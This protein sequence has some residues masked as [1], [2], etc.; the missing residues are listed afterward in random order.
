MQTSISVVVSLAS[1]L[2]CL[3]CSSIAERSFSLAPADALSRPEQPASGSV[4][5]GGRFTQLPKR[6]SRTLQEQLNDLAAQGYRLV[7]SHGGRLFERR[8][9]ESAR[10]EYLVLPLQRIKEFEPAINRAIAQGYRLLPGELRWYD[11]DRLEAVMERRTPSVERPGPRVSTYEFRIVGSNF[12]RWANYINDGYRVI[13]IYES[14]SD[15]ATPS[16][17]MQK[18]SGVEIA[19]PASAFARDRFKWGNAA[20]FLFSSSKL[21][22]RLN[23]YGRQ[24]YQL[25]VVGEGHSPDLL[26]KTAAAKRPEYVVVQHR[27]STTERA[28]NDA[29]SR[30]F[31]LRHYYGENT[32]VMEKLAGASSTEYRVVDLVALNTTDAGWIEEFSAVAVV[33]LRTAALGKLVSESVVLERR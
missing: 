13:K 6:D 32:F 33:R 29:A 15:T 24:G 20:F 19:E 9:N 16:A 1:L 14:D 26:E 23:E 27:D 7:S 18:V 5:Q 28:L 11:G 10:V 3:V 25:I 31:R 22:R 21:E 30:G 2:S 4:P 8:Q 17:L 12:S